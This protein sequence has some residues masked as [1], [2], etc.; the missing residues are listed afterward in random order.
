MSQVRTRMEDKGDKAR[1][2][3]EEE[4][5]HVQA[6]KQTVVQPF[7]DGKYHQG[8]GAQWKRLCSQAGHCKADENDWFSS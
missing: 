4:T 7:P 6:W 3:Q 1:V 2:V 8:D 5:A